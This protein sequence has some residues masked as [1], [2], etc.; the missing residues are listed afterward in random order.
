MN[1]HVP[2][3]TSPS[4]WRVCQFRHAR[5]P[6]GSGEALLSINQSV[7]QLGSANITRTECMTVKPLNHSPA[8]LSF[9]IVPYRSCLG[10]S[11]PGN[12]PVYHLMGGNAFAYITKGKPIL[13]KP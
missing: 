10:H 7:C 11:L 1:P 3:D 8:R 2:K 12:K 5:T 9:S 13:E 6:R 4:S